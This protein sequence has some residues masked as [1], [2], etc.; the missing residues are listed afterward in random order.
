MADPAKAPAMKPIVDRARTLQMAVGVGYVEC[1]ASAASESYVHYNTAVHSSAAA[2]RLI[3]KNCKIHLP[4]T[5]ELFESEDA[6]DQLEKRFFHPSNLEFEAFKA[7]D[8]IS[9]A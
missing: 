9:G 2:D 1:G 7:P 8:L 5:F 3:A 4:S 6:A